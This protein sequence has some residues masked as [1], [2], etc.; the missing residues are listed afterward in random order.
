[1]NIL[2]VLGN[3]FDLNVGLSTSYRDFYDYYKAVRTFNKSIQQLKSDI[4]ENIENWSDLELSLGEYTVNFDSA[5]EF[6]NVFEDIGDNLA[7]YLL[8]V[9]KELKINEHSCER[10]KKQLCRPEQFLPKAQ[11]NIISKFRNTWSEEKWFVEVI[12]FNYTKTFEKLINTESDYEHIS[13]HGNQKPI[14]YRGIKHVHGYMDSR[15]VMGVNDFNQVANNSLVSSQSFIDAFIKVESNKSM[16]HTIDDQCEYQISNANLICLFGC[17]I[18]STDRI[19]W[20]HIGQRILKGNCLLIIFSKEQDI[21]ER[22]DYKKNAF[23]NQVVDRF[24]KQSGLNKDEQK[25]VQK[26]IFVEINSRMFSEL[27]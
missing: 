4:Y 26:K 19:W 15:M 8:K 3:G 12:T 2:Y 23:R 16:Q 5:E 7:D 20:E 1:M 21:P 6:L 18:G 25:E 11:Q 27:I 17:S 13:Y 9:E 22:R 10:L 24:L 14:I